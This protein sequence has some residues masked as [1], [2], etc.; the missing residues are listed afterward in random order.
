MNMKDRLRKYIRVLIVARKPNRDEFIS[1]S[2]VSAAGIV[3]IGLIGF[4][5]F[6]VFLFA[7][8]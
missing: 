1:A 3:L 7:G 2:K 4:A 8:I 5:I 6:L